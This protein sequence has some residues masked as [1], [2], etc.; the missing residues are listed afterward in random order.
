M[1]Q[2]TSQ[3]AGTRAERGPAELEAMGAGR[4]DN[5]EQEGLFATIRG[6]TQTHVRRA[7]GPFDG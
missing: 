6:Q 1:S 4:G 3:Q 2:G 7:A 5:S